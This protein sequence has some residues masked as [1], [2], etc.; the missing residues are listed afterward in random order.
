VGGDD[1]LETGE[2]VLFARVADGWGDRVV[3][4]GLQVVDPAVDLTPSAVARRLGE[5]HLT[6]AT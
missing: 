2:F 3:D 6:P 4:D 5:A 1:L